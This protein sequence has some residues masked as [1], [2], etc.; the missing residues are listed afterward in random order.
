MNS[1][2]RPSRSLSTLPFRLGVA[3][4]VQEYGKGIGKRGKGT[5]FLR[6]RDYINLSRHLVDEMGDVGVGVSLGGSV[7]PPRTGKVPRRSTGPTT[8]DHSL[9]RPL[10]HLQSLFPS[11]R[12]GRSGN[13]KETHS[14]IPS[15]DSQKS[16][17]YYPR[18]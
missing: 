4:M 6:T 8:S 7:H 2:G 5:T 12:I 18:L 13:R 11:S 14:L 9:P 15:G 10:R 3:R 16:S 1:P 17:P